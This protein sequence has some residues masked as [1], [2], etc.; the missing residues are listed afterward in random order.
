MR[1]LQPCG[2]NAA[3]HRH[4]SHDEVPCEP[5]LDA[6]RADARRRF[7]HRPVKLKPCGTPAAYRRHLRR[8]ERACAACRR[9]HCDA[10]LAHIRQRVAS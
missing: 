5:C 8:G 9:A 7:G 4:L 3:Y 1:T 2:T 6:H 10:V